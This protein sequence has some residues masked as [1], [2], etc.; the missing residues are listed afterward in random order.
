MSEAKE[1]TREEKLQARLDA[2]EAKRKTIAETRSAEA[3]ERSVEDAEALARLE[4]AFPDGFAR[5]ELNAPLAGCPGFV[6]ARD[7]TAAEF[8][9]YKAGVKVRVVDKAAEVDSG[10]G[11]AQL[12]RVCLIFPEPDV[13]KKMCAV[14]ADLESGLGQEVVSRAQTRKA[15]DAKK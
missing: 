6:A 9:R 12:G 7:C 3:F 4:E 2:A 13:F 11:A 10:E 5:V 1:P 15:D 14:R 8:K